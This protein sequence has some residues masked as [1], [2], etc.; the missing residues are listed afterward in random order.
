MSEEDKKGVDLSDVLKN[1]PPRGSASQSPELGQS[2][3]PPKIIELVI[4]H[5]GGLVKDEKQANYVI[6]GFVTLAIVISL[7][8]FF[9]G[10]ETSKIRLEDFENKPQFL[11]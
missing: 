4:K 9:G 7:F 6:L 10:G 1:A 11:P 5:S 3:Q 2:Y 8:L